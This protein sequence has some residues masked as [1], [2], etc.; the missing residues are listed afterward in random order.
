MPLRSYTLVHRKARLS[1][2]QVRIIMDCTEAAKL[3]LQ[4]K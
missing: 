3:E 2:A 4:Q 1:D